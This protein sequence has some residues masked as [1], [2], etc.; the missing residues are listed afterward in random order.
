MLL[1]QGGQ[2]VPSLG[3]VLDRIAAA[4]PGAR[5]HIFRD[6]GHVPHLTVPDEYAGVVAGFLNAIAVAHPYEER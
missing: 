1:T 2:G 6:A 3:V 4:L 5:R